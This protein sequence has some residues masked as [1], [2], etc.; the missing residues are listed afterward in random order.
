MPAALNPL[1]SFLR[2]SAQ[3]AGNMHM[4]AACRSRWNEDDRNHAAET[5]ERLVRGCYGRDGD[6][7][8]EMAFYRFQI[9]ERL[10]R[11][12]K[13]NYRSKLADIQGAVDEAVN[14]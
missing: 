8:P 11:A 2:A 6:N 13:F 1:P 10:E 14:G 4:R 5:L 7:Q 9:A 3:D 12:G